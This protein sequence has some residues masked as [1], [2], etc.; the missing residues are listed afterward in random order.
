MIS[1]IIFV[2]FV[3]WFIIK[4]ILQMYHVEKHVKNLKIFSTFIPIIGNAYKLI[5]KSPNEMFQEFV[6]FALKHDTPYK[7]YFGSELYIV[8]DKPEDVKIALTQCLDKPLVYDFFPYKSGLGNE[9]C[10]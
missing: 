9:R 4:Y 3:S 5:G 6:Q 8:I 1:V 7:K 2:I 10:M